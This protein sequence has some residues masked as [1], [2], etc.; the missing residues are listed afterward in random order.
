MAKSCV[1]KSV[2]ELPDTLN[3][4]HI[5][6]VLGVS[7]AGARR[8]VESVETA[9][10]KV[11]EDGKRILVIPA[12]Q[13]G[14]NCKIQIN[15]DAF[16]RA[17]GYQPL[18]LTS[19]LAQTPLIWNVEDVA[20]YQGCHEITAY[21]MIRRVAAKGVVFYIGKRIKVCREAWLL[22]TGYQPPITTDLQAT[23]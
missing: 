1:Y 11:T 9:A 19:E 15:K 8:A 23:A 14:E 3:M 2:T 10:P 4:K 13:S 21:E 5:A 20:K 17:I 7:Q 16:L 12:F 22:F 6:A 18:V